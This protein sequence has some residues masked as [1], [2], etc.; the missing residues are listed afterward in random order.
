[1][2]KKF[3]ILASKRDLA[4]MNIAEQLLK[5]KKNLV[6]GIISRDKE[7]KFFDIFIVDESILYEEN[8]NLD[9]I[10]EYDFVIFASKH[11]SEKNEKALTIHAPGNFSFEEPKF[12]GKPGKLCKT[13]ALFQKHLFQKL[14][15]NAEKAVLKKYEVTMEATHHGPL[16]NKPCLFIEIGSTETE[17]KDKRAG[18]A[19]AKTI[20][21]AIEEFKINPY[22]EIAIGLGGP[23]YCPEFNKIQ[24]DS[25]VAV[26]HVIPKYLSPITEEALKEAW[27]KTDEEPD[28]FLVD[29]K[30]LGNAEERQKVIEVLEKTKLPWKKLGEIER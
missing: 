26:S 8:L 18:F 30:G 11:K 2:Y 3:L 27:K 29:W 10:S 23:H 25:N 6:S 22:Y 1:M 4:G 19:V 9:K 16:I 21:E 24:L 28:F 15:E 12:G 7:D 20:S 13:S 17:W 14:K 5:F